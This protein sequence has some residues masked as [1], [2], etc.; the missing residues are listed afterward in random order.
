M[1]DMVDQ[2]L[3]KLLHKLNIDTTYNLRRNPLPVPA[4]KWRVQ[5]HDLSSRS[6]ILLFY[7]ES[8]HSLDIQMEPYINYS[9]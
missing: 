6:T 3:L 8:I 9:V 7:H 5:H 1:K 2:K 4:V